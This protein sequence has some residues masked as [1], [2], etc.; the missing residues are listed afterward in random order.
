LKE[1]ENP[2]YQNLW[3]PA[4]SVLEGILQLYKKGLKSVIRNL[5]KKLEKEQ[6]T[7]VEKENEIDI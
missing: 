5:A 2:L 4:N 1:N 3:G 6:S 7:T